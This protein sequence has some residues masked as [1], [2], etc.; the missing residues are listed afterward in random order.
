MNTLASVVFG[1]YGPENKERKINGVIG[2]DFLYPVMNE[3]LPTL[4]DCS[5]KAVRDIGQNGEREIACF[6]LD[7]SGLF[8]SHSDFLASEADKL[9]FFGGTEQGTWPIEN[10]F[11]GKK[12]PDLADALIDANVFVPL[13]SRTPDSR[14]TVNYYK[15]NETLFKE[16]PVVSGQINIGHSKCL[17][18]PEGL[19]PD[20]TW[21]V[22][23]VADSNAFMLVVDGYRRKSIECTLKTESEAATTRSN[24]D[25]V[26]ECGKQQQFMHEAHSWQ[27]SCPHNTFQHG[28][29]CIA[30]PIN[31]HLIGHQG[32][33]SNAC[34]CDAGF[35]SQA[36]HDS[37]NNIER[38]N[39]LRCPGASTSAA[40]STTSS[41]CLC[42]KNLFKDGEICK[43]CPILAISPFGSTT[44]D[45]CV[46]P[47]SH[48]RVVGDQGVQCV[49][50]PQ[51]KTVD[52]EGASCVFCRSGTFKDIAGISPCLECTSDTWSNKVGATASSEC[53]GCSFDRTTASRTGQS[54]QSDCHCRKSLYFL[55]A[56][57]NSCVDC[58]FG[59]DCSSKDNV[60]LAGVSGTPGFWKSG[61][62]STIFSDCRTAYPGRPTHIA[63]ARCCP[64]DPTTNLSICMNLHL[65]DTDL[66][67]Q[68][69]KGYSGPLCRVCA[70]NYV[71]VNGDCTFCK[72]GGNVGS[73]ILSLLVCCVPIVFI[74]LIAL[75][76]VSITKF[77]SGSVL[78]GQIKI[79][80]SFFQILASL[81]NVLDSVPWPFMW[82]ELMKPLALIN[83]DVLDFAS[84]AS[85]NMSLVFTSRFLLHMTLPVLFIASAFVAYCISLLIRPV[86]DKY[87]RQSILFKICVV[88]ILL[89]YPSLSTKVFQMFR[90]KSYQGV[91]AGKLLEIDFAVVCW[92]PEHLNYVFIAIACFLLYIVGIPLSV[93]LV[94]RI[95]RDHLWDTDHNH[96]HVISFRLGGLYQQCKKLSFCWFVNVL[97]VFLCV[98]WCGGDMCT[99]PERLFVFF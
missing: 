29:D 35:F 91:D 22:A 78:V 3:M 73:G 30:C 38:L 1:A 8:L 92:S 39:C 49:L 19:S 96:H 7:L 44:V 26:D 46:C 2:F 76:K 9:H 58:P 94:L 72:G 60:E 41:D 62:N 66:S 70:N 64:M 79:L 21:F 25:I 6:L 93:Y 12:E 5:A 14:N 11:V 28:K 32:P 85:C 20:V 90:C 13:S 95:H 59:G 15:V 4:T 37:I 74:S 43:D 84:V 61:A 34:R 23:H 56:T 82:S 77:N 16:S 51:G 42:N 40:G 63:E 45:Q 68:C 18:A 69:K 89:L 97:F 48:V 83:V 50:C 75:L 65:N 80:V 55:N 99:V 47:V 81:P 17:Q 53:I 33:S 88:G 24:L 31:S 10:V 54:K 98:W 52:R 86:K 36:F 67:A 87:I 27:T 57:A 71:Y